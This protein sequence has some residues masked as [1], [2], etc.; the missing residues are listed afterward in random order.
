MKKT[1]PAEYSGKIHSILEQHWGYQSF[2][3][4]Q[5]DII[6]SVLG[7]KDTLALLPTGG[8]KSICF[9]VPALA[10][11]GVC[12]VISPLIALMKDQVEHLVERDIPAVAIYS[13]LS[14]REVNLA[15]DNC[16]N[17]GK[18][19]LYMS[20]ERLRSKAVQSRLEQMNVNL[21][22][23]DEAHC[24]SQWGYD[25][26]PEYL[27]IAE[28]REMLP[29]VPVLA[30][31]ASATPDVV[32]DIQE[33]LHF[34]KRNV[35][36]K[37]FERKNLSY[38]VRNTEDKL[39]KMAE[40]LHKVK[41]SG[42]VYVRNRKMTEEISKFLN[43]KSIHAD[44]YHAGLAHQLRVER[45]NAWIRNRTRIMVC[46]NAFGMGIDKPDVRIV[47]H[48]EMPDSLESYYQE[49]GRA[50]RDEKKSF[51][52]LLF[53]KPDE[54]DARDKLEQNFPSIK[55][56]S[57][58]YQSLCNYYSLPVGAGPDRS[59]DLDITSFANRFKFR[60]ALVYTALK[61]LEQCDLVTLSESFYE[62]SRLRFIIPHD[63]IY[64]F[65]VEHLQFDD[66]IKL[67]LRSY[68][69][70]FDEYVLI[71]E[72]ALAKRAKTDLK[73][74]S[75][76][77][78]KLGNLGILDYEQRKDTPQVTF[79]TARISKEAISPLLKP[80]KTRKRMATLK[81]DSMLHYANNQTLCRSR[82]LVAYFDEFGIEDCGICDIC[83][84]RKS[85]KISPQ[86]FKQLI[87]QIMEICVKPQPLSAL[88]DQLDVN[89]E[90]IVEAVRYLLEGNK[91]NYNKKQELVKS[92]S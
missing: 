6:L 66:F 82:E 47:V 4:L 59:F 19:F 23:V 80:L 70:L 25:F 34:K 87:E 21:L 71:D 69:G 92:H 20:P 17:G 40:I 53:S 85:S 7:K 12:I 26:R 31:T 63:Q 61:A 46:T 79:T 8:G 35:F 36:V 16:V 18:R 37:S 83:L 48:Y 10:M 52:V 68:G 38:V 42:L 86:N 74:I 55:E 72:S 62:P 60:P 33:Q 78:K 58:I 75:T 88:N 90:H 43:K 3:P 1:D 30:L 9:Q 28:I 49:A 65:Q 22:A 91:I 14:W 81:L 73:T 15:L 27:R 45:Q 39:N 56:I 24:I 67:L 84:Q 5:E 57:T 89:P 44:Y 13:G 54:H 2:R 76:L 51:A 77:L 32:M 41:G 64:K 50:G 29:G 11:D